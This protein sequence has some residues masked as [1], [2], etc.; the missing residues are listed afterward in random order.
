M[1]IRECHLLGLFVDALASF[2]FKAITASDGP[3]GIEKAKKE[4]PD[5]I[6]LD[7]M[8]SEMGGFEV[9]RRIR[10]DPDL[11]DTPIIILTAMVDPKLNLKGFRAGANLALQEP[12]EPKKLMG[13][14]K[15]ALALKPK[16]PTP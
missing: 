11:K 13:T 15:A 3:S 2:D 6:L 5:L 10:A 9:C 7:I 8:M 16:P 1:A 14:I 4:H 12:F